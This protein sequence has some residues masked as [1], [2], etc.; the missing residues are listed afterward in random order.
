MTAQTVLEMAFH[1]IKF[2]GRQ[3]V[4]L[5]GKEQCDGNFWQ[6]MLE[7]TYDLPAA[8]DWFLCRDNWMHLYSSIVSNSVASVHDTDANEP[9]R[10]HTQ[11]CIHMYNK[12]LYSLS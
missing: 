11:K 12:Q 3:G 5:R 7:R 2:L 1:S 10:V 9:T 4:P 6:M 8:H